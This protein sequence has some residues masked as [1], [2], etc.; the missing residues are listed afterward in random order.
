MSRDWRFLN[1]FLML[2]LCLGASST[3]RADSSPARLVA[4]LRQQIETERSQAHLLHDRLVK[5]YITMYS[6]PW[7]NRPYPPNRAAP[8]VAI[9]DLET[10]WDSKGGALAPTFRF[11]LHNVGSEPITNLDLRCTYYLPGG[12]KFGS[13]GDGLV[14]NV[15]QIIAPGQWMTVLFGSNRYTGESVIRPLTVRAEIDLSTYEGTHLLRQITISPKPQR[16]PPVESL[17]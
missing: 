1:L 10:W 9:T 5:D 6:A 11:H 14:P 7:R 17:R 3:V 4:R 2:W 8:A 15:V 16:L 12:T 13:S